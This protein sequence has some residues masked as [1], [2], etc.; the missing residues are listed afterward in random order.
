MYNFLGKPPFINFTTKD[1]LPD[2]NVRAIQLDVNGAMW[3]GT[4]KGLSRY[5]GKGFVTFNTD[6][7]KGL[8]SNCIDVIHCDPNE[9]MWFGTREVYVL[10]NGISIYDG[11]T[12][13]IITEIFTGTD[14]DQGTNKV[15]AIHSTPAGVVWLTTKEG[16]V[17][18]Y[19]GKTFDR[20]TIEDE[21]EDGSIYS[22][23]CA[24]DDII[25]FGSRDG[26]V[27]RYD[28][29][30]DILDK[31]Y[32]E[33]NG[34]AY[35]RS[36]FIG[37]IICGASDGGIWF[38]TNQSG[39]YYYNGEELVNY[40][41]DD[42]LASNIVKAVYCSSDGMMWFGTDHAGV[43]GYDGAAWTTLD[44]R[45]G[46]AGNQVTSICQDTEGY[47]WFGT[48]GGITRYHPGKSRPK[49]RLISLT[50]DQ[51]YR[52]LTT[53]PAFSPGTR[54]T[55]EYNSTDLKTIPEKRQYRCRIRGIDSDWRKPTK[56][57]SFDF[58]FDEPGAY[59]F[60]VQA[61][62]RDL[63][64]SKPASIELEVIPDPRNH[65]LVQLRGELAERE[66][67]ELERVH[68]E[69]EDARQIQQSLLPESPPEVEGFEIAGTSLPA[70]EV[71]GDFYDYLSLGENVG[72]VLADVTGK[73]VKAAMVAALANGTLNAELK[74]RRELWHS[75]S[76]IFGELN[77]ALRP[78]LVRG[79]FTA[80]SLGIL[81]PDEKRL[82]FSN[83]GMPYPIVK[84]GNEVWELELNGMPLGIMKMAE[85]DELNADLQPGDFVIFCSDG[86]IESVNEA[87][88]MYEIQRLL[89][90]VQKADSD[91]SA[92]GMMD[93]ILKDVTEFAGDVEPADDITIVVIRCD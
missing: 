35:R 67:A 54:V 93:W 90:L 41:T 74:G 34:L 31:I 55:I 71:S 28:S 72:I 92:Q 12:F 51:I 8:G 6:S 40:T 73:S 91:L 53:I 44:T 42:G 10:S 59:T 36:A 45:D 70:K 68:Q 32:E 46:L 2:N 11:E 49:V 50:T 66:R 3:I 61:I 87:E 52:D 29:K 82:I 76:R 83:A 30:N 38:T 24:P 81:Y 13:K 4:A 9:A 16:G 27:Y 77:A 84:H 21:L 14:R 78:R 33:R 89:E 65:Q 57:D 26:E 18:V 88:E 69:L 79:M 56:A 23:Y 47:L 37:S 15:G 64:Y 17:F 75:P 48:S 62:D 58:M 25:W 86:V 22:I 43:I 63:N 5:D 7:E 60:E 80:M 39:V 1:G 85:Y 19:N 20:L